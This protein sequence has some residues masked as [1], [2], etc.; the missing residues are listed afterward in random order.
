MGLV[1]FLLPLNIV[2]LFKSNFGFKKLLNFFSHDKSIAEKYPT[3]KKKI[4]IKMC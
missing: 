2:L 4:S 3:K 1:E